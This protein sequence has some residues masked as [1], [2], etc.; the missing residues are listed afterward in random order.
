MKL[1]GFIAAT[2]VCTFL[3]YG[4]I[5]FL[6]DKLDLG[7]KK[8]NKFL[9]SGTALLNGAALLIALLLISVLKVKQI[10]VNYLFVDYV[11][12]LALAV[13][14]VTDICKNLIPNKILVIL[15]LLWT[16]IAGFGILD[17]F[18]LGLAFVFQ[19]LI[20]GIVAGLIFLLCYLL[21]RKQLGAG[22][23]KLVF[24]MGLYLTG[25]LIIGAIF[26]GV[27]LCCVYSFFQLI[28]K[29]I[30]MKDG[31]PL[32]PFLYMGTIITLLIF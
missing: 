3:Y 13:L 29:K 10:E 19:S 23:V 14:S 12:L 30:G 17:N 24:V 25:Q 22:D 26:Y 27:V 1:V 20:G 11:I 7:L 31:V 9:I 5:L 6:N 4:I 16:G 32:V 15:L 8:K 28:R 18:E 21:S 2:F